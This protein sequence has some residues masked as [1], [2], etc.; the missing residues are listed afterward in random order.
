MLVY[1]VYCVYCVF[2][3]GTITPRR[4]PCLGNLLGSKSHPAL[5]S[6]IERVFL[7]MTS[8]HIWRKH[9]ALSEAQGRNNYPNGGFCLR[10]WLPSVF[11]LNI[12]TLEDGMTQITMAGNGSDVN[13]RYRKSHR[14]NNN[15][16][17]SKMSLVKHMEPT[18]TSLCSFTIKVEIKS[19]KTSGR[20]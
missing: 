20:F 4:I 3:A 12:D 19:S 17:E 10:C 6:E 9:G 1:C 2:L 16:S 15:R 8:W 14:S 5:R 11:F 7:R 18:L 13:T